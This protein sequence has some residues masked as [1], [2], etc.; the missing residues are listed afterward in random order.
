MKKS[1]VFILLLCLAGCTMPC[2]SDYCLDSAGV[3]IGKYAPGDSH[4]WGHSLY[5]DNCGWE[6]AL[7]IKMGISQEEIRQRILQD[8]VKCLQCGLILK[9]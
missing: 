7:L 5:C 4:Y 9:K 6:Y 8:K 1:L 3:V 2:K